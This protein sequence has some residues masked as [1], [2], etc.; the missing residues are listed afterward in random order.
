MPNIATFLGQLVF[1][2]GIDKQENNGQRSRKIETILQ[3]H[4]VSK[5]V[6]ART[7]LRSRHSRDVNCLGVRRLAEAGYPSN[8][9][10][11][12]VVMQVV[13]VLPILTH[14]KMQWKGVEYWRLALIY[15][16]LDGNTR[17]DESLWHS[18]TSII[19]IYFQ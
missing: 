3:F 4:I 18:R 10:R 12:T 13:T 16:V 9:I 19:T 5:Y 2:Q 1:I 8:N 17:R 6:I 15:S 7:G 14:Q 11:W